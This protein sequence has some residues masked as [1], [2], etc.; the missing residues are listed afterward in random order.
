MGE[1]LRRSELNHLLFGRVVSENAHDF[2]LIV[3][4]HDL[5]GHKIIDALIINREASR[6]RKDFVKIKSKL[7]IFGQT[8]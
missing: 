3:H 6:A 7:R 4:F 5:R 8:S 1:T 2:F